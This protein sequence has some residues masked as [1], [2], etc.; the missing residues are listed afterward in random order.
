MQVQ[1]SSC[2]VNKFQM[3]WRI[4]VL[5]I[6]FILEEQLVCIT[7]SI[8]TAKLSTAS[9]TR[10]CLVLRHSRNTT[11]RW[12][13]LQAVYNTCES[14]EGY[15]F[16]KSVLLLDVIVTSKSIISLVCF[17]GSENNGL[18]MIRFSLYK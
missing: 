1:K 15:R 9:D 8:Y 18:E 17:I 16:L 11:E 13:L 4:F 12:S 2:C 14:S 10:K 5:P 3:E 6:V 7:I